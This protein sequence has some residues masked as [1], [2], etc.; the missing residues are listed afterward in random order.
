[1]LVTAGGL[2]VDG[3]PGGAGAEVLLVVG[4]QGLLFVGVRWLA[5]AMSGES[6]TTVL[7]NGRTR[8]SPVK[9]DSASGAKF[10]FIPNRPVLTVI[11]PVARFRR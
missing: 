9:L 11:S 10:S 8:S 7:S 2:F 4:V 5:S 3:G 6:L 1:L